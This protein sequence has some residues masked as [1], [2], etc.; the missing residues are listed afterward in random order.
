MTRPLHNPELLR[1]I[2]ELKQRVTTLER[3]LDADRLA[4]LHDGVTWYMDGLLTLKEWG[5]WP[6]P[7]SRRL[8]VVEANL[9]ITGATDTV[10]AINRN[11][12][13][14]VEITLPASKDAR[15]GT[16]SVRMNPGDILTA[17]TTTIGDDAEGLSL[18]ARFVP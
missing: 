5:G 3:R 12:T 10:A 1:E 18:T 6:C 7:D 2:S 8:A 16:V 17:E 13:E 14:A 15:T 9:I 11:G 4:D